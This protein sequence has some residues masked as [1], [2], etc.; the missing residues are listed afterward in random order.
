MSPCSIR[1]AVV[2]AKAA[3][4]CIGVFTGYV[5]GNMVTARTDD[6]TLVYLVHGV[7]A[8]PM[9]F[10]T[11]LIPRSKRW[12]L[13][14]GHR[15]EAKESMQFIYK[16]NIDAAFERLSSSI[17][18][19][20]MIKKH[21]STPGSME[22]SDA[23]VWSSRLFT[24]PFRPALKAALGLIVF[25]QLSGQPSVLSY[26]AVLFAAAGWSGNALVATAIL[27]SCASFLTVLLVDHVGRKRMLLVCCSV[28]FVS[29]LV[30]GVSFRDWTEGDVVEPS[31]KVLL[32]GALFAYIAGYQLGFGPVTWLIVS[33]VLPQD[34][35]GLGT[36]LAV[37]L[38]YVVNFTVQLLLPVIQD[39]IGWSAT[40]LLFSI[41]IMA[42]FL[43][44]HI[45]VPETAGL[46]LEEIEEQLM[47]KH[48]DFISNDNETSPLVTTIVRQHGSLHI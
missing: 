46:P 31:T 43:F 27:M 38:N 30:L 13:T 47:R 40:F 17:M 34:V 28:L 23:A 10:L 3:V 41:A 39:L 1:G 26:S 16:G 4:I 5:I 37:E 9:L 19:N 36:A 21:S 44:V 29:L 8:L 2:S 11:F 20:R 14:H 18:N 48:D 7:V 12:L 32:L 42:A 6:W 22:G 25:Q 24:A 45:N 15:H 33:E 35:R